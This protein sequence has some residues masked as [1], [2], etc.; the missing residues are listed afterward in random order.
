ME[1]VLFSE[2]VK[3][4]L[5]ALARARSSVF[6]VSGGSITRTHRTSAAGG[7]LQSPEPLHFSAARKTPNY[8]KILNGTYLWFNPSR[9]KT[10]VFIHFK[11]LTIFPYSKPN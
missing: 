2:C 8:L 3:Y 9:F 1:F 11:A 5:N 7:F 10:E 6:L 4:S